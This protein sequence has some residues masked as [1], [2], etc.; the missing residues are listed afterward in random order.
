MQ[1]EGS[2]VCCDAGGVVV[3]NDGSTR[4]LRQP[5]KI[6]LFSRDHK[7]SCHCAHKMATVS[8]YVI[9]I[10]VG[11]RMMH[12]CTIWWIHFRTLLALPK[13]ERCC[14]FVLLVRNNACKDLSAGFPLT[15]LRHH[16]LGLTVINEVRNPKA[17]RCLGIK[18]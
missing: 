13:I 3:M 7:Q 6:R 12:T 4:S 15:A 1:I 18:H 17:I 8:I 11:S 14:A 9:K 5:K 10:T 2:K 16:K